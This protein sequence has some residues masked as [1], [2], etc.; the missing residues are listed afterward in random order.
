MV[1]KNF[2]EFKKKI[3]PAM[4]SFKAAFNA[5]KEGAMALIQPFIDL[6]TQI[7]GG[8]GDAA[9]QV[10]FIGAAVNVVAEIVEFLAKVI[11]VTFQ[12]IGKVIR[13]FLG[14]WVSAFRGI[15]DIIKGF[16]KILSGDVLG[17]LKQVFGGVIKTVY[18]L[19]GPFRFV[20]DWILKG[21][22]LLA[23]GASKALG[24][25]PGLGGKVKGAVKGLEKLQGFFKG[26]AGFKANVKVQGKGKIEKNDI[27]T[28]EAQ[29]KI[30]NATGTGVKEGAAAGAKELAKTLATRLKNLKKEVQEEVMNRIK[31]AIDD[32]VASMTDALKSQKEQA[33]QIYDDQIEK[34]NSLKKKEEELTKTKEY[35]NRKR[36]IEAKRAL[37]A[38][39]SQRAYELAIY[40]GRI[41]DAREITFER[42]RAEQ[43]S[44]KELEDLNANRQKE[45]DDAARENLIDTIN[46]AKKK[47][48]EYF[49]D[50][51]KKFT[52]SA[53][54]IT[55]FPPTTAEEFRSQLEQLGTAATEAANSIGT[56]FSSSFTGLLGNLG[57]DSQGPLTTALE[58][59][60]KILTDNNP[61]GADGVWQKSIDGAIE[62]LTRKY[63]GLY[64]TLTT[65]ID[66]KTDKF[67]KLFDT[68]NKYQTLVD[69]EAG[70]TGGVGGVGGGKDTPGTTGAQ[71]GYYYRTK[72]RGQK[73]WSSWIGPRKLDEINA[74]KPILQKTGLF[75]SRL[76]NYNPGLVNVGGAGNATS[77]ISSIVRA[78]G[79]VI[80][81]AQG[82]PTQGPVQQGIPAIL[83]G[84]EY[85]VRNSAVKKYGWGMM[86]QIN[87]GTFKPKPFANGG[88]VKETTRQLGQK[89]TGKDASAHK[90]WKEQMAKKYANEEYWLA[91]GKAETGVDSSGRTPRWRRKKLQR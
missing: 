17:G 2:D 48:Q 78:V 91:V 25:I 21:L 71:P 80:P 90:E 33:L 63:D 83:H 69:Q 15:F 37:N 85:V 87:Q 13:Y 42:Q 65:V 70:G 43:D 76:S 6:F 35:E 45:L 20:F 88:M 28:D 7:G 18:G 57:I 32:V 82:G 61:F 46:L 53:K 1:A 72:E 59:I 29:E 52:D 86:Q 60:G 31:N 68:Y 4:E 56:N 10:S 3:A 34:I 8:S 40:E 26:A 24:W 79:G 30:A 14:G 47:A 54:K 41:D 50:M 36:E 84:G 12:I 9:S 16:K 19:L 39:N 23:K 44:N 89:W 11:K 67:K 27:D 38:L 77:T 55:E 49:D 81:F 5:L 58:G 73:N 51:I 66:T 74:L 75:E 22:I 62:Y 64:N